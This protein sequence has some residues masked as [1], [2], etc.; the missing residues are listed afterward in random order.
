MRRSRIAILLVI[1]V[2]P[3][4]LNGFWNPL[5]ASRPRWFWIVEVLTWIILPLAL[6]SWGGWRHLVTNAELG[7]HKSVCG[8]RNEWVFGLCLVA[9]P[10]LMVWLDG[11][12]YDIVPRFVPVNRWQVP[13]KYNDMIPSPGP[14]TGRYRL[15]ALLHLALTAG[16]VEGFYYCGLLRLLF[17]AGWGGA[18]LFVLISSILFAGSHWEGGTQK[19][20]YA[21]AWGI[22][23]ATVYAVTRNLWP[24]VVGHMFVDITWLT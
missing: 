1:G 18:A 2:L 9:A 17:R 10:F 12:L 15:L 20:V 13:F 21:L 6:Y 24:I 19:L 7:F 4:Y 8:S 11:R 22:V 23:M 14:H 5:L 16:L 3:L